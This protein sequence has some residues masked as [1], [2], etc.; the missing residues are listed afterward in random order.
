MKDNIKPGKIDGV[1]I[2]E[3]KVW[4]DKPDLEQDIEP[5]IFMEV[6]RDDDEMLKKFGQSNFT[7]AHKGTIK[8][9]HWHKEQGT[10]KYQLSSKAA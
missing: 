5:G 2:K 1:L 7:I 9:F 8:A 3:L 6:L 10:K 4:K